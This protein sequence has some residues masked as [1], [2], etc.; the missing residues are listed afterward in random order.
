VTPI[1][2][3]DTFASNYLQLVLHT[4]IFYSSVRVQMLILLFLIRL[5]LCDHSF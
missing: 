1:I 5:L 3:G 4:C 2:K